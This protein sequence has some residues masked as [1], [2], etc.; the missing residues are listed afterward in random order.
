MPLRRSTRRNVTLLSGLAATLIGL[1]LSGGV[2]SGLRTIAN[3]AVSPF[4]VAIRFVAT[5][6]GH[7]LSGSF[8]YANLVQQ[9]Q[10]LRYQLGQAQLRLNESHAFEVQMAHM[11]SALNVHF[12]GNLPMVAAQVSSFAPTSFAAT[13]DI[14][15]GRDDGVLVGMP[16]VANGGLVGT[17]ISTTLH[18]ATVRLL[19]DQR[20]QFGTTFANQ[21]TS[22]IVSGQGLNNGL[23]ATNVPI[24]SNARPGMMVYTD[25]LLGGLYPAGLPVARV[26][27]VRLTPGA[28]TYELNLHPTADL[29]H[30]YYVDVVLWEPST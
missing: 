27:R 21:L 1:Q 25:G 23:A 17:V 20:S 3:G 26:S 28:A 24:S 5:P 13:I 10:Q 2:V 19:T 14:S 18:G 16:V 9:N 29:R 7:A 4:A 8:N 30:I 6:V 12:V 15:K 22:V 11:T